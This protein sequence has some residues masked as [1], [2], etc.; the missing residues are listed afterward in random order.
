[1]AVPGLFFNAFFRNRIT[2]IAMDTANIA[3]DLLTQ[4]YHNSKRP[5]APVVATTVPPAPDPRS[6]TPTQAISTK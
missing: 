4:M 3:D 2:R 5:S 6:S 1:L